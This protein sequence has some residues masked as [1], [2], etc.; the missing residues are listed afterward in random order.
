MNN[1]RVYIQDTEEIIFRSTDYGNWDLLLKDICLI[2]EYTTEEGPFVEDHFLVFVKCNAEILDLPVS[3][4]GFLELIRILSSKFECQI[5]LKLNLQTK[6][7]SRIIFPENL[8]DEGLFS[9][10][11]D[12]GIFKNFLSFFKTKLVL[13][14]VA[15][16]YLNVVNGDF[17]YSSS[18][19]K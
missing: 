18:H 15:K 16:E 14:T 5:T 6:F 11:Q 9:I 4:L 8:K 12:C 1:S 7:I 13:N 3:S 10:K 17:Y 2:G 19:M